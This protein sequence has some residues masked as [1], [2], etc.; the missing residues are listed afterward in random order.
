MSG[1]TIRDAWPRLEPPF[2][3]QPFFLAHLLIADISEDQ[4]ELVFQ[5]IGPA[6]V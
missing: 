4:C 3:L 5:T 2:G 6:H 1:E